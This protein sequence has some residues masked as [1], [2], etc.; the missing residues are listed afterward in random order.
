MM[1][2]SQKMLKASGTTTSSSMIETHR[3]IKTD[4]PMPATDFRVTP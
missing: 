1:E 4:V 3:E 2:S